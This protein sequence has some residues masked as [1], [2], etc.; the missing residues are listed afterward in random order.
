[1][2]NKSF[3]YSIFAALFLS[4]CGLPVLAETGLELMQKYQSLHDVDAEYTHSSMTLVDKK[5]RKRERIMQTYEKKSASGENRSLLKFLLPKKITNVGL[6]TWQH[7]G[8]TD[9]DQWLY[10]PASKRVK[11][12]ASA[13]KKNRFMGSDLSFEDMQAEDLQAHIYKVVGEEEIN[14][15]SCWK[16]EALPATQKEARASAYGKR[17]IWLRKDITYPVKVEFYNSRDA[18]IKQAS[19]EELTQ[20]ENS[21][22]RHN[23]SV[24][25][26]PKKMTSTV[27]LIDKRQIGLTIE[28]NQFNQQALKR[29][30]VLN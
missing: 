27:I 1:M 19:Y 16:I 15:Q 13:G 17:I 24:M 26:T 9:D 11:R 7:S 14:G 22:W 29:L 6:L 25:S 5:G 18:L 3:T 12:I 23:K 4:L 30:P 20:V 8:E 10:L 21:V 2:L 28:E